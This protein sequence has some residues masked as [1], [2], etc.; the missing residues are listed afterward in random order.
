[1]YK[2]KNQQSPEYHIYSDGS[3]Y[4]G[5]GS[6]VQFNLLYG[7]IFSIIGFKYIDILDVDTFKFDTLWYEYSSIT[8]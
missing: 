5:Y 7:N 1:M 3:I 4:L 6:D 2:I 8:I